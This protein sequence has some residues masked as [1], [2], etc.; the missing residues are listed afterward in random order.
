MKRFV[1]GE[2]PVQLPE[3]YAGEG[4]A[5]HVH[6]D[7]EYV[8]HIVPNGAIHHGARVNVPRRI[9]GTGECPAQQGGPQV[10]GKRGEPDDE[11]A[12]DYTLRAIQGYGGGCRVRIVVVRGRRILVVRLMLVSWALMLWWMLQ[13]EEEITIIFRYYDELLICPAINLFVVVE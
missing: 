9:P 7:P 12:E 6:R 5:H 13:G 11:E 3:V 1:P 8:E 2:V 10:D 4:D